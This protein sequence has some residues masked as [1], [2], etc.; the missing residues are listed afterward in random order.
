M[1]LSQNPIFLFTCG[2]ISLLSVWGAGLAWKSDLI[3]QDLTKKTLQNAETQGFDWLRVSF[4]GRDATLRG[5]IQTETE[6]KNIL[7]LVEN[8]FGVRTVKDE[9]SEPP[10]EKAAFRIQKEVDKVIFTGLVAG[11]NN[12]LFLREMAALANEEILEDFSE[13]DYNLPSDDW[14]EASLHALMIISY[15]KSAK[16]TISNNLI[17]IEGYAADP[18]AAIA[19]APA[20]P[21]NYKTQY[22]LSPISMQKSESCES[23][24][25]HFQTTNR[26]YFDSNS[27]KIRDDSQNALDQ[28]ANFLKRCPQ[29][30]ILIEGH[31]DS[32]GHQEM[33]YILSWRRAE[34]VVEAFVKRGFQRDRFMAQGLGAS[35]PIARND[36]NKGREKNRRIEFFIR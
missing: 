7:S 34:A 17:F 30:H 16:A 9:L 36:N 2:G 24:I 26:L 4:D 20:P 1:P 28:I 11:E 5:F 14:T 13:A 19:A 3:E 31:T 15:A 27:A 25:N 12:R 8:Q 18:K 33:N 35:L 10:K 22:K 6:R 32:S 23:D 29:K 21:K